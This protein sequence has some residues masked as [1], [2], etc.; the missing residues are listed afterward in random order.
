MKDLTDEELNELLSCIKL[1]YDYDL[2][3]YARASLTRRVNRFLI[4]TNIQKL[5]FLIEKLR[6]G[7]QNLFDHFLSELTVNVTEMFRDPSFYKALRE[8]VIPKLNTYP[9]IKIWDAGCS[10]GEE[11]YSLAILLKEEKVLK[12][13][14]I[15]A[16]DINNR[17]LYTAKEGIYPLH[18]IQDYSKNYQKTGGSNDFAD[19]YLAKYNNAII[20]SEFKENI[21]FANHNLVSDSTFNEFNLI[22]CRNVMIYFQRE[23]Q[24]KVL[25]LFLNSLCM[26]GYLALGSK[27]S[28]SLSKVRDHFEV[29]DAKD[30]I[31]RRIK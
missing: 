8:H 9:H 11:T 15:Y 6:S 3:G 31:Y 28:L 18:L 20:D 22:V 23:L 21:I 5:P 14:K 26:Y 30:K 10:T 19:Y 1:Y 29:V 7:D 25:Q 17:V 16:T 2:S 24:E 27:E 12:K 13:S 4:N